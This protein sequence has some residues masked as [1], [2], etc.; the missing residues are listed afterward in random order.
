MYNLESD[1]EGVYKTVFEAESD[2]S[3]S[4]DSE[5]TMLFLIFVRM[6]RLVK[7]V[8]TFSKHCHHHPIKQKVASTYW[9]SSVTPN[10]WYHLHTMGTNGVIPNM[11]SNPELRV[12]LYIQNFSCKT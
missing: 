4:D 8:E 11:G 2:A 3:K 10:H 6:M 5:K 12:S 1:L 9:T 7:K